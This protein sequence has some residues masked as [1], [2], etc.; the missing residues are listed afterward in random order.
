VAG[1]IVLAEINQRDEWWINFP[2]YQ[3]HE[4][5]AKALIAVQ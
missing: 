1:K 3:A 2:V 4:K 5:G